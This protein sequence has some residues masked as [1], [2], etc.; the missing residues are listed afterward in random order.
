M[1]SN[2][3]ANQEILIG[4]SSSCM[5]VYFSTTT[6]SKEAQVLLNYAFETPESEMITV[7]G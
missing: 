3:G 2:Q 4:P 1:L 5:Y 7:I 6:V